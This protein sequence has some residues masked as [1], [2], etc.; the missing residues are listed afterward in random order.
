VQAVAIPVSLL[1]ELLNAH[2]TASE[3]IRGLVARAGAVVRALAARESGL[4][5]LLHSD[6]R[7]LL[8]DCAGLLSCEQG[9]E[10]R[11]GPP[12]PPPSY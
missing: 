6:Q 3:A 10:L 8:C 11:V 4:S 7:A 2:E 1:A 12:S 9:D 5:A